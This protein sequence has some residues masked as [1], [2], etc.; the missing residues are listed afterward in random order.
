MAEQDHN[1]AKGEQEGTNKKSFYLVLIVLLILLNGFFAFNHWSTKKELEKVEGERTELDSLYNFVQSEL[2][3]SEMRLDS[4]TGE[5][6]KLDSLRELHVSE[7]S[8]ARAE[9]EK[10]LNQKQLG[11]NEISYLKKKILKLSKDNKAYIAQIDSLSTKVKYL[12][13]MNDSLSTDLLSEKQLTENL[14]SERAILSKK[15]ALGSLLRPENVE[16]VGIRLRGNGAEKETGRANKSDKLRF[17]FDIP[18]NHVADKG[19]KTILLRLLNPQGATVAIKSQ[20]SGIFIVA[21]T[22]EQMQYTTKGTF[23]YE[24][25][26]KSVCMYWSQ[27]NPFPEG[28]YTAYFY[29][30]GH[31][32]KEQKFVLK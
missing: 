29:Q 2:S 1:T 19:E 15:V 12:T 21:E 25:K 26:S 28:D 6:V 18:E 32:L 7:L 17:C 10:L 31:L 23:D 9:I 8:A 13:L 5:N 24:G 4:M 27:T 14:Q 20:G 22:G 16:A 3:L 30:D 11:L